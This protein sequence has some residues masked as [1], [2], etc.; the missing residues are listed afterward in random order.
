MYH[1]SRR[2]SIAIMYNRRLPLHPAVESM[3]GSFTSLAPLEIDLTGD[4]NFCELLRDLQNQ[5]L[6]I[7][8]HRWCAGLDVLQSLSAVFGHTGRSPLP[9]VLSSGIGGGT[10]G[11]SSSSFGANAVRGVYHPPQIFID[12]IASQSSK[13]LVLQYYYNASAFPPGLQQNITD[14]LGAMIEHLSYDPQL[15]QS[16]R[17][18]GLSS[19]CAELLTFTN[20]ATQV[21]PSGLLC[22]GLTASAQMEPLS[23]SLATPH[24]DLTYSKCYDLARGL[25]CEFLDALALAPNDIV[26][27]VL[28]KSAWMSIVSHA[29]HFANA[30]YTPIDPTLPSQRIAGICSDAQI[31]LMCTSYK[32]CSLCP[33][34]ILN[35]AVEGCLALPANAN[36]SAP[37]QL[38]TDR[39]YVIFTSG[40]T[41]KPK[42]VVLDHRGPKNTCVDV[43][44][45]YHVHASDALFGISSFGFDLSVYDL[46]GSTLATATL[47][48]PRAEDTRNPATW[49]PL[50]RSQHVTV[51][52][53]APALMQLLLDTS[54]DKERLPELRLVMLSGDWIPPSMPNRIQQ[55]APSAT[56]VSLGGA[57]EASIWSIWYEASTPI[58]ASWP[59]IPYGHAMANQLWHVL[60]TDNEECPMWVPGELYIGG[61]GL[62][63]GYLD[64]V[65]TAERFV[66][67]TS[68]GERLYCTGDL[69]RRSADGEIEF[70]G[71]VDFQVKIGGFRVELGEIE[72]A[73]RSQPG[74]LEAVVQALGERND[75]YL[76]AWI[77]PEDG[78]RVLS[79]HDLTAA[80]DSLLPSY[81]VPKIMVFVET[82]P[83]TSNGKLDR[84]ALQVPRSEPRSEPS[85]T[86]CP[87]NEHEA[88]MLALFREFGHS[89]ID[90]DDNFFEAGGSSLRAM[91][92]AVKLRQVWGVAVGIG[93]V[94]GRPTARLLS[95]ILRDAVATS[96][97][98][99]RMDLRHGNDAHA[100]PV[101]LA[102]PEDGQ[103]SHYRRLLQLVPD[104][105]IFG[106]KAAGLA[107]GQDADVSIEAMADRYVNAI[108]EF[109]PASAFTLAG[110]SVGGLIALEMASKLVSLHQSVERVVLINTKPHTSELK[111]GCTITQLGDEKFS[112]EA[113]NW[114]DATLGHLGLPRPDD[115]GSSDLARVFAVP[116]AILQAAAAYV[117]H[118][119]PVSVRLIRASTYQLGEYNDS[120]SGNLEDWGWNNLDLGISMTVHWINATHSSLL[121]DATAPCVAAIVAR[122]FT[123]ESGSSD[124]DTQ[125]DA[126]WTECTSEVAKRKM[127]NESQK[128]QCSPIE[129]Y[130][131]S[132][133]LKLMH[134]CGLLVDVDTAFSEAG[135]CSLRAVTLRNAIQGVMPAELVLPVELFL[136]QSSVRQITTFVE[137]TLRKMHT[138]TQP[139]PE[140][141]FLLETAEKGIFVH[142]MS[143]LVPGAINSL[144][145]LRLTT[146]SAFD[147]NGL[148]SRSNLAHVQQYGYFISCAELFSHASFGLASGEVMM[149]DPQ[150]RQ[151]LEQSYAAL[152]ASGMTPGLSAACVMASRALGSCV[153]A[154]LAWPPP[155]L[156]AAFGL[157]SRALGLVYAGFV[158]LARAA[159]VGCIRDGL[160]CAQPRARAR[161]ARLAF[162]APAACMR[163]GLACA[164]LCVRPLRSLYLCHAC[165]LR[166]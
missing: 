143:C 121:D 134:G 19:S 111:L 24:M 68:L 126:T 125:R 65:K 93:D 37:R 91:Q 2:F 39:A 147:G 13:G 38:S 66:I 100:F 90:L 140:S 153:L 99:S 76:A 105:S 164:R 72:Q 148:H 53:S 20:G 159:P 4:R 70:L 28:S 133:L 27:V 139:L 41:G 73:L 62:A 94:M 36:L 95:S 124:V 5:L 59:S 22:D 160:A 75:R 156:S 128:Y 114:I 158:C 17:P 44:S 80:L 45:Q 69:G 48:Y 7:R 96:Q 157:A 34:E 117:L 12:V 9:Y 35:V 57:T 166:V 161:F 30:A 63:M 132:I 146:S 108:R 26:G 152:H 103:V 54:D 136:E 106:F 60:N 149:M 142:G 14:S 40:S 110:W 97:W 107:D 56:I 162:A 151:V 135:M 25:A 77:Q 87:P 51:W 29:I 32:Y 58:P 92:L 78:D 109:F 11:I 1:N 33:E 165:W 46:F 144:S 52:N 16:P 122:H 130:S 18:R 127:L 123:S 31:H 64:P 81:M 21:V 150:Q 86:V 8:Q 118:A 101:L 137:Q 163:D 115:L 82:F 129:S 71:R 49:M 120:D 145:A 141:P 42:G 85:M 47:V 104:Q 98:S 155:R 61:I 3:V 83:V 88:A 15:W 131:S 50:L 79:A 102:H 74:V 112:P 67:K 10:A 6:D 84:Q 89:G 119:V 23:L 138:D 43:N 113:I 55:L 116:F 154:S